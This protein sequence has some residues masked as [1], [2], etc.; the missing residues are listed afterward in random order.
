[1]EKVCRY[2]A[3][4]EQEKNYSEIVQE[5]I[6]LHSIMGCYVS[7]KLRSLHSHLDFLFPEVMGDFSDEIVK[8]SSG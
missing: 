7:L 4:N 6:S 5:L 1:L 2:V 3:G 8:V